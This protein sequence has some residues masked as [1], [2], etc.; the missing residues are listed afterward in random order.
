MFHP[1]GRFPAVRRILKKD[2]AY[3]KR[4]YVKPELE[5]VMF[6]PESMLANSFMPTDPNPGESAT[7]KMQGGWNQ[8]Q[9]TEN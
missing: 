3:M 2:K 9:W 6:S 7:K 1:C 8:E 5:V 4:N